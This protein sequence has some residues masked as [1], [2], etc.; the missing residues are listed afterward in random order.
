MAKPGHLS[1]FLHLISLAN[2]SWK[3]KMN[4]VFVFSYN[5]EIVICYRCS[6]SVFTGTTK[7]FINYI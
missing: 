5:D 6:V 7:S 3:E 2:E 4:C 1:F